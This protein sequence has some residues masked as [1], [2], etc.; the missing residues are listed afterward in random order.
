MF[1]SVSS[2][3]DTV[4][5]EGYRLYYI[6]HNPNRIENTAIVI[7]YISD[8]KQSIWLSFPAIIVTRLLTKGQ[9]SVDM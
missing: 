1:I 4:P 6:Y 7:E 9:V 3:G 8:A 2:Q 5:A